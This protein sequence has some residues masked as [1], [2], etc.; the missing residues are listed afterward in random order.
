MGLGPVCTCPL[1]DPQLF[2][3]ILVILIN[4]LLLFYFCNHMSAC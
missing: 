4:L 2:L 3:I 1:G